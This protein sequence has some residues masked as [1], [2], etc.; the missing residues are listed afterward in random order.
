MDNLNE[1]GAESHVLKVNLG[2]VNSLIKARNGGLIEDAGDVE[3]DGK[4]WNNISHI[5]QQLDISEDEDKY[6]YS[7]AKL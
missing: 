4:P 6:D 2:N 5:K 7:N 1:P 3:I